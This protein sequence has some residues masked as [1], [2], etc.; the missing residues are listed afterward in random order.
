M[1]DK[2]IDCLVVGGGPAGLT[3][4]IYLARFHLNTVVV[5]AGNGR[6]TWIPTSHNHAGFPEGIHGADLVAKMAEQAR[7]YGAHVVKS[8]VTRLDV[9]EERGGFKAEWGSGSVHARAVL[10]ATGVMNRRPAMD[11]DLHDEAMAAGACVLASDIGAFSRVLDGGRSGA[12]FRNENPA[13]LAAVLLSLLADPARRESLATAGSARARQFD[14]SVVADQ[15]LAVYET[16]IEGRLAARSEPRT[17]WNR[18][19]RGGAG[20]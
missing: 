20:R 18:L 17:G 12:M 19:L 16:V 10:L 14:W 9:D 5:D 7:M 6:A 13:D 15:I 8:R 4:A 1:S 11:K 3:A 2:S